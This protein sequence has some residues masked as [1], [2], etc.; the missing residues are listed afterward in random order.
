MWVTV[1]G[2][3]TQSFDDSSFR[4][5]G[6]EWEDKQ[7]IALKSAQH[8]KAW[9]QDKVNGIVPCESPGVMSADLTTFTFQ[10][11]NTQQYP[12]KDVQW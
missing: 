3:R 9:W 2:I 10:H 1:S 6:V 12:L 5:A 4:M 7:V 11:T 8:F